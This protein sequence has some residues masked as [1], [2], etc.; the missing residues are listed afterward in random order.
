MAEWCNEMVA[1]TKMLWLKAVEES[2]DFI[3]AFD[4]SQEQGPIAHESL[5]KV[6]GFDDI[7]VK[8]KPES[9]EIPTEISEPTTLCKKIP[10]LPDMMALQKKYPLDDSKVIYLCNGK[11]S[12]E[13][14]A[15]Q[16]GFSLLKIN[17][18]LKKYQK[19]KIINIKRV[20]K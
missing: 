11:N 19:K 9:V 6:A 15:E 1:L 13:E 3:S 2:T 4:V 17:E 5:K 14:I 12:I 16:T 20:I 7:T 10:Y 18:I 8:P